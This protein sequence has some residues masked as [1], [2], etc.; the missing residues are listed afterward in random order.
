MA[1][2]FE[3]RV[4]VVTPFKRLPFKNRPSWTSTGNDPLYFGRHFLRCASRESNGL[5][6]ADWND[7]NTIFKE[8]L[9]GPSG[10]KGWSTASL[11]SAKNCFLDC[12]SVLLD[13]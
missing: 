3:L 7:F 9:R 1:L 11:A 12:T 4:F 13:A 8:L 5:I 10:S 2:T 6:I